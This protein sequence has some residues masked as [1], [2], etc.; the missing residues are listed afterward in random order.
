MNIRLVA[1]LLIAGVLLVGSLSSAQTPVP[2]HHSHVSGAPWPSLAPQPPG[3]QRP[4]YIPR[5]TIDSK[6]VRQFLNSPTPLPAS[7]LPKN[8]IKRKPQVQSTP[9]TFKSIGN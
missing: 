6:M 1:A 3:R 9:Q 2:Q 8:Q 7:N 4:G 5:I